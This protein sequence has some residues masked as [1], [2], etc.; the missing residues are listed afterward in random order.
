VTSGIAGVAAGAGKVGQ[1]SVELL[2][3]SSL[4]G[5]DAELLRSEVDS[6]L[7]RIKAV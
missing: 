7:E 1:A 3:A 2:S 6:F 5:R 4:L